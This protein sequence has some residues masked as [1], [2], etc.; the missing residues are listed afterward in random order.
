MKKP[1]IFFN[2]EASPPKESSENISMK[3]IARIVK[4]LGI[5]YSNLRPMTSDFYFFIISNLDKNENI[6]YHFPG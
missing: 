3:M 1:R 5:Q 2:T 4:I 6:S